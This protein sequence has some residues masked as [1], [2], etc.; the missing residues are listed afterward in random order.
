MWPPAGR[1]HG[2]IIAAY[3]E[4]GDEELP[5]PHV[6]PERD[7]HAA[8]TAY[9]VDSCPQGLLSFYAGTV[10]RELGVTGGKL[11]VGVS[12]GYADVAAPVNHLTTGRA[13]LEATTAFHS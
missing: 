5:G 13:P 7:D 11:L 12:F 1:R 4:I 9:G 6:E 10:R 3:G 8:R 2:P